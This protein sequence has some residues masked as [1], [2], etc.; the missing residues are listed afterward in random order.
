MQRP[1]ICREYSICGMLLA[2]W[3]VP[4]ADPAPAPA[5]PEQELGVYPLVLLWVH[6]CPSCEYILFP[7]AEHSWASQ[8]HVGKQIVCGQ[9]FRATAS[10]AL[11]NSC[12]APGAAK[13][14]LLLV[15]FLFP[16][17]CQRPN[18]IRPYYTLR[19]RW[20]CVVQRNFLALIMGTIT[21]SQ[22]VP[23]HMED[24][25]NYAHEV[26]SPGCPCSDDT[27]WTVIGR[28]SL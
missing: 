26:F 8:S 1:G 11:Q 17:F 23:R 14:M 3:A 16:W 9:L 22:K 21:L 24:T 18:K 12:L 6:V 20:V 28:K 13:E 27:Q 4:G 10:A 5:C 15:I 19:A 2:H 7:S 25:L